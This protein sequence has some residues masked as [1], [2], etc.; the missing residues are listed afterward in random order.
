[1]LDRVRMDLNQYNKSQ[2]ISIVV[3]HGRVV[4]NS[5]QDHVVTNSRHI[6][7]VNQ[8]RAQLQPCVEVLGK[9]FISCCLCPPSSDGYL[10]E[11]KMKNCK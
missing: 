5:R 6:T 10:V 4:T 2:S 1:M 7:E 11:R 8:R 9:P 3:A